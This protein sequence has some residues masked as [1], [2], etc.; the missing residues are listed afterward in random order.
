MAGSGGRLGSSNQIAPSVFSHLTQAHY[1]IRRVSEEPACWSQMTN[2][3]I[4]WRPPPLGE[5]PMAGALA[6][7]G[8]A[9]PAALRGEGERALR[10]LWIQQYQTRQEQAR[11]GPEHVSNQ[12]LDLSAERVPQHS[13]PIRLW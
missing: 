12:S 11:I 5:F 13:P 1:E 2:L 6:E 3:L 10:P 8:R 7:I 4:A 9:P